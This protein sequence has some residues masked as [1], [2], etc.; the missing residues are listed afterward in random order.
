MV[1][2]NKIRLL[3]WQ[4]RRVVLYAF[5]LINT[6]RLSLW[7][8]PFGVVRRQLRTFLPNYKSDCSITGVISVLFIV[9]AVAI[10]ANYS[11][12]HPK[13]L[14]RALTAQILLNQYGYSHNLHIGIAKNEARE[15]EAHAWIEYRGQVIVGMLSNLDQFKTLAVRGVEL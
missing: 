6:I 11:L 5:C 15:L 4:Q 12:G 7:L 14:A 8:F 3:S 10:A 2:L 13:C 1:R 9:Q